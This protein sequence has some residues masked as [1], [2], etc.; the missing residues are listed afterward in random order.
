[1][2]DTPQSFE[3]HSRMVP[4]YHHAATLLL[5]ASVLLSIY[6]L[7]RYFSGASVLGLFLSFA[8]SI[9]FW[10]SR[11]FPLAVQDRIIRLE[12]R[13]RI[14]RLCP[15]LRSRVGEFT[16]GQLV[17]LRFASD[18]ELPA[19]ARRVLDEK[20]VSRTEIKKSIRNWCPDHLRV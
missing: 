17:S 2:A 7:V 15:D 11:V 19:L 12:E 3:N 5:L 1:M 16:V 4:M 13:L 18:D 6:Q 10:Y 8:L 9:V 14:E 20:I